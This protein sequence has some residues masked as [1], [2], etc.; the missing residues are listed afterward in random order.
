MVYN[1]N[2]SPGPRPLTEEDRLEIHLGNGPLHVD[3]ATF[4]SKANRQN[5]YFLDREVQRTESYSGIDGINAQDRALQE[6]MGPIVDRSKEH[7]GP[8]DQ[9]I[10]QARKLLRADVRA[11]AAGEQPFGT[12]TSYYALRAGEAVLPREADWR[13]ALAPDLQEAAILATV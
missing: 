3:Q 4:R 2:Y 10:I 13:Q 9:A 12:G 6:S 1:W 7:L 8:A 5:N 11:V